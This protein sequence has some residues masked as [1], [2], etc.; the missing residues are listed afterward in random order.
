MLKKILALALL[1]VFL[2]LPVTAEA[3]PLRRAAKGVGKAGRVAAKVVTA[4]VRGLKKLFCRGC[5]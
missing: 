5:D 1:S 3:G 4:P 2:A